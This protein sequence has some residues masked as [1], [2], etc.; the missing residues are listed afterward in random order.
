MDSIPATRPLDGVLV[1]DLSRYLPGPLVTRLLADLGARVLKI[2]EPKL[3]DPSRNSPP[4]LDG[5][6]SLASL[7]LAGHESVALDLKKDGARDLLEDLLMSADVMVESFR[8]GT[9]KRLGLDPEELRELFPSLVICS[10]TGWGQD[11]EHAWRAG[12][13][14]SYQAIAGSL[15]AG[16]GIPAV[17]VADMVGGWSGAMAVVSALFRRGQTGLGCWIDQSLTDAAGHA[18]VTAWSAEADGPK[19]VAEPLLLTGAIPCYDLY[20]TQDGGT[21]ALAALEPKFWFKFCAAVDRKDLRTKQFSSDPAV[22]REVADVV[23]ARSR[24][25]WAALMAEHDIPAEPVLSLAESLEHPQIKVRDMVR[26]A[27]DG[28]VQLGYPAKIDGE[29]PRVDAGLRPLGGDTDA[30][31]QEFGL[32]T[33]LSPLSKRRAGVGKRFS[34]RRWATR[35]V[36]EW[37]GK[38][39]SRDRD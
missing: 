35:A 10:V 17:Q 23:A 21:L 7:L 37:V 19:G 30:V 2:E 13:D 1:V 11:G 33:G 25:E 3:G 18:A 22:R 4:M 26:K 27:D 9:L 39:R 28:F 36:T 34:V 5:H 12:H 31:L 8:P 14:L 6:S 16:G 32:A 38:R 24:D 15:S 20:R 29:R